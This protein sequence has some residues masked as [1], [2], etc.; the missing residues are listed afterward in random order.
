[1]SALWS[2]P[3][4]MSITSSS[5]SSSSASAITKCVAFSQ[6]HSSTTFSHVFFFRMSRS[7]L[8]FEF[9][10]FDISCYLYPQSQ[11]GQEMAWACSICRTKKTSLWKLLLWMGNS[12]L[13]FGNCSSWL[14]FLHDTSINVWAVQDNSI[15]RVLCLG[16]AIHA[17]EC[18]AADHPAQ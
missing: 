1:M 3:G 11:M 5:S 10:G 6:Q 4:A 15:W 13:P 17:F 8:L 14:R 12:I 16:N 18:T 2:A 7:S 9:D